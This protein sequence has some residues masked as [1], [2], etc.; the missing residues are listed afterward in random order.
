MKKMTKPAIKGLYAITQDELDSEKLFQQVAAAL[1]G[2]ASVI[3][4]RNKAASQQVA[5][6]Q[7]TALSSLCRSHAATFI[8]NDDVELALKVEADGVH[9]GSSDGSLRE[10]R[11]KLGEGKIL[12]ASC[13]NRLEIAQFAEQNTADYIAFGACFPSATKP[14]APKADLMLFTKAKPILTV[15]MVAIGGIT[16]ENAVQ[17]IH[18]GADAVAV[19]STLWASPDI[20]KTARAFSALF[21]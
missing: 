4:Y 21:D 8:V 11:K 20:E 9:L 7:A 13:Y 10:A 2:G 12:G 15:P 17:V 18:A 5:L 16:L 14:L 6:E 1:K 19:I 3:Q